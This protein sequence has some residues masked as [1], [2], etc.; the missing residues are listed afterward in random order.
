MLSNWLLQYEIPP[1]VQSGEVGADRMKLEKGYALGISRVIV[2][3]PYQYDPFL[4]SFSVFT[5]AGRATRFCYINYN[6]NS[7]NMS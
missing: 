5:T 1:F 3:A 4:L 7:A 6:F 2:T